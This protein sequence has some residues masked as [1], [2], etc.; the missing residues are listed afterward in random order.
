M[1]KNVIILLFLFVNSLFS[2]EIKSLY[3]FSTKTLEGE[4]YNLSDLKGKKVMIVNTAS[5]CGLT[6]QYEDL[7]KLY[8]KYKDRD[9][10]IIAFPSNDFFS[11]EPGNNKEIREF[12][13]NNYNISF[14]VMEKINVKG[15]NIHPIYKWLTNK[16]LNGINDSSTKWNFQKYLIGKNGNLEKV[17]SPRT[18][19]F[20]KEIIEWIEK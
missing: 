15:K 3:D 19:P 16:N 6:S 20:D 9:F 11:Q 18:D 10:V 8:E 1:K 5:K 4:N 17:I 2:Q 7:E 13:T 14:P 12:C